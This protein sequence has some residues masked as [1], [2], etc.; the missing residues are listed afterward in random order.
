MYQKDMW[1]VALVVDPFKREEHHCEE[2]DELKLSE[3]TFPPKVLL[4]PWSERRQVII[5]VH[6][7]VHQ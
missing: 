4:E 6:D 7:D 5:Q 1:K 2:L 3:V